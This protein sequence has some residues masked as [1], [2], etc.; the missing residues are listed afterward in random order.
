M[1]QIWLM[2]CAAFLLL[3]ACTVP[4]AAP[5]AASP[6]P[7]AASAAPAPSPDPASSQA[8]ETL[9]PLE[10]GVVQEPAALLAA[11]DGCVSFGEGEAGSS[12]KSAIAAAGLVDWAEDN[13]RA[14]DIDAAGEL[15]RA[16]LE[17]LEPER[18]SLFWAN[19]PVVDGRASLMVEDLAG[20]LPL[21]EDAG[22]PQRHDAY[23]PACYERLRCAVEQIA[24][25][26]A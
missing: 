15:I 2:I 5:S 21:L 6:A 3:V 18:Q 17:D 16:W 8:Q 10:P 11:L 9:G 22:S 26:D 13:A 7:P 20:Q 25:A 19:W 12:L 1:K 4:G 14:S 23:T 24:E